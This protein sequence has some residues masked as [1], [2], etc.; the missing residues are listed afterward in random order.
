LYIF[1]D[2]FFVHF[3]ALRIYKK[4]IYL[5]MVIVPFFGATGKG[6]SIL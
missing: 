1:Y 3:L 6:L 5:I 2:C 4:A